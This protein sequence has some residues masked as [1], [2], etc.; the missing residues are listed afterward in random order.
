[1]ASAGAAPV[2]GE[3]LD[4][5]RH[6]YIRCSIC[7]REVRLSAVE[8]VQLL[9]RNTPFL[10]LPKRLRCSRC[11]RHGRDGQITAWPCTLIGRRRG[12]T[13]SMVATQRWQGASRS[14]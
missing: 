3:L 9:G 2:I 14:S 4:T 11:G 10:G 6:L 5:N 13:R 8:A 1:M 7:D 12:C